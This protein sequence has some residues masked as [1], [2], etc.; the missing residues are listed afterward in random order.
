VTTPRRSPKFGAFILT[1]AVLGFVVGAAIAYYGPE[2]PT[3]ATSS[4]VGFI[5]L[6]IAAVGALAGALV[7][8]ALDR[9]V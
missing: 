3:Y 9:R 7:A 8:I 5:G 2:T 4:G 1:G 6:L